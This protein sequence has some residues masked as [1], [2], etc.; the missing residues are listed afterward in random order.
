MVKLFLGLAASY[1][2]VRSWVGVSAELDRSQRGVES[3]LSKVFS[4]WLSLRLF[5]FFLVI[6][7]ADFFSVDPNIPNIHSL[8]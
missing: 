6:L 1:R 3:V 2:K 7:V 8:K 5:L 4:L